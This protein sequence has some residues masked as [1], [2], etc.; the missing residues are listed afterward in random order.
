MRPFGTWKLPVILLGLGGAMALSPACKAQEVNPDHFTDTGIEG[1]TSA[2]PHKTAAAKPKQSASALQARNE[3]SDSPATVQ[4]ASKRES[5]LPPRSSD[6]A[7][8]AKLKT[9][10][11]NPKKSEK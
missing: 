4:L 6:V 1:A 7:V 11:R 5:S 9:T 10:A 2:A 3:S 8:P